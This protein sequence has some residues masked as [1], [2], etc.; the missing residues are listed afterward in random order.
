MCIKP[1][2]L[3]KAVLLLVAFH[4]TARAQSDSANFDQYGGWEKIRANAT[5]YFRTENVAGR[6]WLITPEGNAFYYLGINKI[7]YF[8]AQ[9]QRAFRVKYQSDPFAWS[10]ATMDRLKEWRFTGMGDRAVRALLKNINQ[11]LVDPMPYVVMFPFLPDE[12]L[13]RVYLPG[14]PL[15][16]D[17]PDVFAPDF[18]AEVDSIIREV[19]T[20]VKDDPFLI[21]YYTGN[22]LD[23]G[24]QRLNRW[25]KSIINQPSGTAGKDTF[26]TLIRMRY[27]DDIVAF[28]DVYGSN[29]TDFNALG[30]LKFNSIYDSVRDSTTALSDLRAFN[31]MLAETF[32]KI[33]YTKAKAYDPNHL[34]MGNKFDM[35]G[36]DPAVF[37]VIGPYTDVVA[38]N[39]YPTQPIP[40]VE[41]Y[42]NVYEKTQRPIIHSEFSYVQEPWTGKLNQCRMGC[43]PGVATQIARG[44]A[45]VKFLSQLVQIPIVMGACWHEFLDP[46]SAS[47]SSL[48]NFGVIDSTD[49]PYAVLVDSMRSF[50]EKIYTHFAPD[51]TGVNDASKRALREF[52]LRQNYPNPFN[53]STTIR[54]SLP[55]REHVTLKVFDVIGRE[56]ATLVDEKLNPGEHSVVYDAKSLSSGLYICRLQVGQHVQQIKMEMVK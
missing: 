16:D 46:G 52:A 6:W 25:V 42:Q 43:Y 24:I 18:A 49:T 34:V 20:P 41:L 23:F 48:I 12:A 22:E 11:R 4:V 19:T 40:P 35:S 9:Y 56:V 14:D 2:S 1:R 45:Y 33:T 3:C 32:Y 26:V 44:E 13:L 54:F 10:R 28:N 29:F 21:G 38:I 50:N 55:N 17:F 5:G 51:T 31:L 27:N 8:Y 37:N 30:D 7:N 47:D 39:R 15:H 36:T 53:P